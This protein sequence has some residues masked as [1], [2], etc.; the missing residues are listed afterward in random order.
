MERRAN[1]VAG[2]VLALICIAALLAVPSRGAAV[3]TQPLYALAQQIGCPYT[4]LLCSGALAPGDSLSDWVAIA[5]GCSGEPVQRSAYLQGLETY[6]TEAYEKN[7]C[8]HRIKATE[9]H[10]IALTVLALGGDPTCFGRDGDGKPVDLIAQGTYNW[11]GT[12]ELGLQ[13]LNALIF[14]LITLDAKNYDIPSGARYTRQELLGQLLAAQT[15][16][17]AFG[18][19][20]GAEDVDLTAMA[21]QALAPYREK[22]SAVADSVERA[23]S[24]LSA[25]QN[26]TGD[27]TSWGAATSEGTAQVVIALCALGLDPGTDP[28]FC[29]SGG[30]ALEGLLRYQL[31]DGMFCHTMDGGADVMATEQAA[32]ALIAVERLAAGKGRLYDLT[33]VAVYPGEASQE[34]P[35]RFRLLWL[36]PLPVLT[37]G[38]VFI[39]RKGKKKHVRNDG[40]DHS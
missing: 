7:G 36:A 29:K 38:A 15:E 35:L 22:D 24:W 26:S 5:T 33:E 21:L 16:A 19:T 37:A 20:A 18:L 4:E 3:Q 6:V 32:L 10:R 2:T 34:Q 28:R 27:F 9:Y 8:L 30:S 39:I 14:A 17:G 13:G 12:G 31:P 23:L 40:S 25:R 11:C 1:R